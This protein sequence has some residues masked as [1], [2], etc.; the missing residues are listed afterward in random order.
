MRVIG[1]GG[2]SKSGRSYVASLIEA[3]CKKHDVSCFRISFKKVLAAMI[4]DTG[5]AIPDAR[6]MHEEF[7]NICLERHHTERSSYNKLCEDEAERYFKEQIMI[8]DD[9]SRIEDI[10]TLNMCNAMLLFVDSSKRI[11][12]RNKQDNL[13]NKYIDGLYPQD[14]FDKVL[15]N[16]GPKTKLKKIMEFAT[17]NLI[18]GD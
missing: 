8:I 5:E 2:T 7:L 10:K 14:L 9:V 12:T 11:K 3:W 16:N 1:I 13:A 15:D 18:Y 4:E 6:I 17:P